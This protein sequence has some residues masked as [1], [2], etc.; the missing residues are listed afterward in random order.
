MVEHTGCGHD[1]AKDVSRLLINA[2]AHYNISEFQV[3]RSGRYLS[4]TVDSLA[5]DGFVR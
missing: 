3:S 2:L 4:V 1:L 5:L